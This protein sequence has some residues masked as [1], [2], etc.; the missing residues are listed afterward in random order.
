MT[1]DHTAAQ[2]RQI[3]AM[4]ADI[5]VQ[6][7]A[8]KKAREDKL[9]QSL[10][11]L[12]SQLGVARDKYLT[13]NGFMQART[14]LDQAAFGKDIDGAYGLARDLAIDMSNL[15]G[16]L[17]H[18]LDQLTADDLDESF[19]DGLLIANF[20]APVEERSVD[21]IAFQL[22]VVNLLQNVGPSIDD[23][24]SFRESTDHGIA[25]LE[26]ALE[27]VKADE[28]DQRIKAGWPAQRPKLRSVK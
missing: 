23:I 16:E 17:T 11:Y 18:K 9:A 20:I 6:I 13:V 12:T 2:L 26:E 19:L 27:K 5:V 15:A 1:K 24:V 4:K 14:T 25:Q 10:A 8:A 28:A 21:A 7:E 3:D 22:L